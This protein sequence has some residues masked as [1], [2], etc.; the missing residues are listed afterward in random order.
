[1]PLNV[2]SLIP[3][4][5]KGA[6][7]FLAFA[8][9]GLGLHARLE[10]YNS[11]SPFNPTSAK[12]STERHPAKILNVLKER[13]EV[14][15]VADRLTFGLTWSSI[16]LEQNCNPITQTVEIGLSSPTRYDLRG[17]YSLHRP[18]PSLT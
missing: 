14:E 2:R 9:F 15:G 11:S 7:L 16:F 18:P 4:I 10:V 17:D 13:R 5:R 8:V 12:V 1:M 3:L 6:I